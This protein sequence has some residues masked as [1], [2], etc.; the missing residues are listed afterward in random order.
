MCALCDSSHAVEALKCM[1]K[2]VYH[3]QDVA[4]TVAF[5]ETDQF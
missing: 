3:K 5:Y 1:D 2:H 4:K